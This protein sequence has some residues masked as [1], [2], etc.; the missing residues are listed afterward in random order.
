MII[1][2]SYTLID[3]NMEI[4]YIKTHIK[5]IDVATYSYDEHCARVNN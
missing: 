1:N 2:E 4:I 3:T 5:L